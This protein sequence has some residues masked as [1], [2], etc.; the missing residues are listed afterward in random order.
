[1]TILQPSLGIKRCF[2]FVDFDLLS[3]AVTAAFTVIFDRQHNK[4]VKVFVS[5]DGQD[6]Y[7]TGDNTIFLVAQKNREFDDVVSTIIHELRHWL[8]DYVFK[9]SFTESN[10]SEASWERYKNSRLEKDARRFEKLY[11][12]VKKIY[13]D[14]LKVQEQNKQ[15]KF[16]RVPKQ[17][18]QKD[19]SQN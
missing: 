16:H 2:G 13:F 6:H 9:I 7:S 12:L 10:Y 1:M 3:I 8:Q 15:E 19:G 4:V 5:K 17:P 11:P 18:K 14:L